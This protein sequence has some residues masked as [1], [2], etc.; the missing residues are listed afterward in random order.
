[1][2]EPR[3]H[4]RAPE[5][6]AEQPPAPQLLLSAPT[7]PMG[8]DADGGAVVLVSQPTVQVAPGA[9]QGEQALVSMAEDPEAPQQETAA[10]QGG[11]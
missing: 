5:R 4:P 2:R 8:H 1:M 9:R 3:A 6:E 11:A 7:V 10:S